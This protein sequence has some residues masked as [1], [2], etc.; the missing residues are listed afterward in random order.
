GQG[1]LRRPGRPPRS[2]DLLQR[3]HRQS[4]R[5]LSGGDEPQALFRLRLAAGL[6]WLLDATRACSTLARSADM[7]SCTPV[8]AGTSIPAGRADAARP[9]IRA[10]SRWRY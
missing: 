10:V 7:R 4:L 5:A 2:V 6:A 3:D 9:S 8:P 1:L